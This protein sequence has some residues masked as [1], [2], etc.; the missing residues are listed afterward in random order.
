MAPGL[1]PQ[2]MAWMQR[3]GAVAGPLSASGEAS[4]G[5]PVLV[6]M[7]VSG[8]WVD[9]TGY[10]LVRDDSGNI[11]VTR[12]IRDEGSQTDPS[13]CQ[14]E[15]D[16]RDGRFSPRNPSGPYFGLI[17]RNTPIRISVPDGLGGKSYRIWGEIS[18]WAPNWDASGSDVW[19]DV[20]ASGILRRLAQGPAPERSV[21]YYAITDPLP[22]SVV[23]YWPMEDASGATSLASALTSGSRMTWTGTPTLA[24]YSG[25]AAS[26]PLPDITSATLS[27]G[28]TKYS[29]PTAT[30]VRF[31]ASIPA[32]GLSLG[33][34]LVAI[35]QLDYSA[36]ASQFWEVYYDT[37]TNSLTIRTCADDGTVLGAELQHS[38]DV[39][40]RL[41]Y[42]SVEL[43]EAGANI[44]RTLR[45]K[46]VTNSNTYTVSDTVFTTQ[47]T[48]VTRVQFGPASRAVSGPAG[49]ANLP[50]VAV[51]HCTVETSITAIDA[52]GVRLNPIGETAGRRM[53]R[54]CDEAGIAF[55]WV[56]DL[57]DTVD[58]GAQGKA[59]TLSL[60]QEAVL[61]D[62]GML[63]ENPA[64]FGLGYRT[65]ASLYNQDPALVLD[66]AA[67]NLAAVPV[68][69]EDDRYIQ[70]KVTVTVNG[71][72]STVEETNSSLGTELPPAGVGVYGQETTLN[73]ATSDEATLQDQA[74]W[75]VHL[76]TV[77]EARYPT[78]AVNL[79]HPS[80]T[81]DMRRAIIGMRAGDRIQITNP[82][83]W[84]PPDVIDQLVLGTSE[85]ITRFEHKVTFTCAPAS[86]Y[87][88]IGV[89]DATISR[90]DTDG[91]ELVG[92]L[93][94]SDTV[95]GVQPAAGLDGLWTK[96]ANDFPLDVEISGEVIR[97]TSI[98]DLVT[99]T[100][101]RT[102]SSNWGTND[103]GLTWTLGG[104]SASDY[105]VGSGVGAHL[106]STVGN[107]R[108]CTVGTTITDMDMYVSI[109]SD[110]LATGDFLAGGLAQRFLDLDN[111]YSAQLRFTPTNTIQVVII[112]RVA[113]TE[114]IL[115]T[116]TMAA[117]TF[118]AGTFYRLRFKV[119]GSLLRAKAWLA[120]DAETPEWQ[121]SVMDGDLITPTFLGVR[122]IAGPSATNVNPSIKYD[123]FAVVSPQR[124]S[125]TR[126]INGVVKSHS[127][128]E[129]VSLATPTYLAL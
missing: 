7:L 112:K 74:A 70:N 66:Y 69:V 113:A 59:N 83:A 3:M 73:L 93:T 10:V 128:G 1:A 71:I 43:Q 91:S 87:S 25:F 2:V 96:D 119:N 125:L 34:V 85:T 56:G 109:T 23:A 63:Y 92:T 79:A 88:S 32:A 77:D 41:L 62:G 82:P 55:D 5:D 20:S 50:G 121:V 53:Q 8:A 29:D 114:T 35:D 28:V 127:R 89:L 103:S 17:G 78:I 61:A 21:I 90:I 94:T 97:V 99:D 76:G 26:D 108:R 124:W 123:D 84:L 118:V 11:A 120:T 129:S 126:S 110:Q 101:S 49:T 31:L 105:S 122:S 42:V 107:S 16:N 57:D 46:D 6:E 51:G 54:L 102:V 45:L 65:R 38:L 37:S 68:P 67:A 58:M 95:A 40:G 9:I 33:K 98:T 52:L 80:I 64:V 44:T 86:P 104:G 47:L 106:L 111:L 27:G 15:L 13:T 116:Y 18:E 75:R 117:T 4:S 14:L 30:Q 22:S 115:G 72:S 36:G 60:I 39:R 48:R 81:A 12:G 100:F 24:S 19:T